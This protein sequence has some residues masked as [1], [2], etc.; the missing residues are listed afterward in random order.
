MIRI[1]ESCE[2]FFDSLDRW[3]IVGEGN[4]ELTPNNVHIYL[5]DF[6]KYPVPDYEF[7]KWE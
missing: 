1:A 7:Y 6:S 3:H 4:G 5:P 2:D